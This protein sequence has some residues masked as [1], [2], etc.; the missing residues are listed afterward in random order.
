MFDERF[1]WLDIPAEDAVA[2]PAAGMA[3]ANP[4]GLVAGR[5]PQA[6]RVGAI[7]D[8]LQ[9]LGLDLPERRVDVLPVAGIWPRETLALYR[10]RR[11]AEVLRLPPAF[12]R[13]LCIDGL[14]F[15]AF[16]HQQ[17]AALRALGEL[18]G[19]ALLADEVG[20][21]K[22][23]EAGLILKE[24][25]LRGLAT[26]VLVLTPAS[27]VRQW[28]EELREKFDED[29][30]IAQGGDDW[31]RPRL[32]ASLDLAKQ[33]RHA[34]LASANAYDLLIVDEAHKLKQH[35]TLAHR[36]VNQLNTRYLLLLTATPVQ[37]DLNE[38]FNLITLLRPGQLGSRRAF[39]GT[40][41]EPGDRQMPRN[42]G[43][44]RER[45]AEVMIRHR[46]S[47]VGLSLPPR[48]AGIYHLVLPPG[49]RALYDGLSDFIQDELA[50]AAGDVGRP[51]LRLVLAV[52]Q[53]GLTSSPAAVAQTLRKLAA[54]PT[55]EPGSH[56]RLKNFLVLAEAIPSSRKSQATAELLTRFGDDKVL[57]FTEFRRTQDH[58]VETLRA[59]GHGVVAFHGGLSP[60]EK[61]AAVAAFRGT[62]R[63]MISTESGGEGLNL[64]FCHVLVNHDLPW[65]PLRV[66]QRIGRLHRLGQTHAVTIFNLACQNTIEAHLVELLVRKIRLF[67]LVVGELDLI[68]G[69]L[70]HHRS[71]EDR[72]YD[73]WRHSRGEAALAA[74]FSGLGRDIA[75]AR[76]GYAGTKRAGDA[77]STLLAPE[78]CNEA[79]PWALSH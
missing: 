46:R 74:A 50:L 20:L 48:R 59:A 37:N 9:A 54:D 75:L 67:E 39:Q 69:D 18:R 79:A 16:P 41:V 53:R 55:I 6:R 33:P 5:V 31:S 65:N 42:E 28:Q 13:L 29:F 64:Q 43:A 61:E 22:T 66:E 12:D 2:V 71:F 62:S 76:A 26:R 25:L 3:V 40:Y 58:L 73:A 36:F 68:L 15:T 57:V 7:A 47:T 49:E 14:G 10:L 45:L 78:I 60:S 51:H 27:L 35:T 63:V 34:A 72:I 77:L 56:A 32:I 52:L 4:P 8:S 70:E 19:R 23:I 17:S 1:E 11:A 30:D 21:G 38:L 24:L 44:L